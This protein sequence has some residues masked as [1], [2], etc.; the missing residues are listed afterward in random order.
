MTGQQIDKD[1]ADEIARYVS[2]WARL[3]TVLRGYSPEEA[4]Q[5][6]E[7]FVRDHLELTLHEP[8]A[9][10]VAPAMVP[11]EFRATLSSQELEQLH[12]DVQF[13]I[14]QGDSAWDLSSDAELV[15]V[16]E[17]V[18]AVLD[19]HRLQSPSE[20]VPPPTRRTAI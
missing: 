6:A 20:V 9:Y 2:V 15:Q 3:L 11:P 18:N 19:S 16:R 1:S 7:P 4:Q 12:S 14:D 5:W 8:P 10:W 17:R 13:A